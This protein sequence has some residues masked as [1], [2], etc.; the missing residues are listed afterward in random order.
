MD[1]TGKVTAEGDDP[2]DRRPKI[3]LTGQGR[4]GAGRLPLLYAKALAEA[5][6]HPEV[7]SPFATLRAEENLPEGLPV[8]MQVDLH[9]PIPLDGASGLVLPGGGDIDPSLYGAEAHPRTRHVSPERDRFES[10]LLQAALERDMPVLCICRGMQL[11]NVHLGGTLD[12]H[13]ADHAETLEHD[14]DMPRA[15]PAHSIH[16]KEG[17]TLQELL[18][19]IELPVNSHH[20]QGLKDL[21][22]DI[23]EVGW[24]G[25]GVLEAIVLSSHTW[26][27]GVQ[28][29]P[30]VMAP[31]D[32]R[33]MRIFT[34]FLAATKRYEQ[35]PHAA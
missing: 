12:Q 18:A 2:S 5:G 8:H 23:E 13:L 28:W 10:T 35:A 32:H 4:E 26:V 34:E 16:L 30:E 1:T 14:R 11:L 9:D 3:V 22:P 33:Q 15:E 25:D 24:A 31:V 17:S 19:E 29:H 20:H 21:A 7:Y 6:A 27:V